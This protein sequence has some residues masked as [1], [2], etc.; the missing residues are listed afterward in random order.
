MKIKNLRLKLIVTAALLL[1]AAALYLLKIPCPIYAISGVKCLGC[2]MTRALVAAVKL[3]FSAAFQYHAMFWSVPLLY[4]CFMLDGKPF[5]HKFLNV[6]IY[7]AVI[8][9][10]ITN[11]MLHNL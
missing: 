8:I 9:G 3:D 10:F 6:L 7:I 4:V 2:G 5:R 11:W 1:Y